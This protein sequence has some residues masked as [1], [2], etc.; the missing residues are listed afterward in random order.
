MNTAVSPDPLSLG[1]RRLRRRS[2]FDLNWVSRQDGTSGWDEMST[3]YKQALCPVS[4][5]CIWRQKVFPIIFIF[6]SERIAFWY[7]LRWLEAI[8]MRILALSFYWSVSVF[9]L[10]SV[11][12]YAR[13]LWSS[14]RHWFV[15]LLA[16][17][18]I[19]LGSMGPLPWCWCSN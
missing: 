8:T 19:L 14:S 6:Q 12:F 1:N 9:L 16:R 10:G 4:L 2:E 5:L 15:P 13:M 17:V 3:F 11:G 7:Q 18:T